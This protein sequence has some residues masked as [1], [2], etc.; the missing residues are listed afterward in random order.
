MYFTDLCECVCGDKTIL[1][2][3][4]DV[5]PRVII[6]AHMFTLMKSR[7]IE[8]VMSDEVFCNLVAACIT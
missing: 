6:H 4:D 5:F 2:N 8:C 1:Y 3:S 7:K